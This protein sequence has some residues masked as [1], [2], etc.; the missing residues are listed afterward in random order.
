MA[1]DTLD[2]A[3]KSDNIRLALLPLEDILYG[4]WGGVHEHIYDDE[5]RNIIYI[6]KTAERVDLYIRMKY[7]FEVVKK[8]FIRLLKNLNRVPKNT[9]FRY[10]TR[11]L[12]DLV[13]AIGTQDD[14]DRSKDIAIE[15]LKHLFEKP[16]VVA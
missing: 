3:E 11:Y 4:V 6:G 9:P 7:P 15:S 14:Y 16:E 13:V 10:N 2:K 5:I 12:S 1:K 8:E